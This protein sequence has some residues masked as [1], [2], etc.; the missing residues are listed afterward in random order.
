QTTIRIVNIRANASGLG[1]SGS[2]VPSQVIAFLAASPS[3]SLPLSFPQQTVGYVQPGLSFDLRNCNNTA[4]ASTSFAQCVGENSSGDRNLINGTNGTMQFAVRFTEG[5]QTAFKP[6]LASGQNPSVP[7][8]TY[9]SESGFLKTP[10]IPNSVGGADSATR[11]VARFTNVPTGARVFVTTGPSIGSSTGFHAVLTRSPD[12]V[13][14][15]ATLFCPLTAS[16]GLASAEIPV[17][18]GTAIAVWEV[19]ETNAAALEAAV[20]GVAIAYTPDAPNRLPGLGL[21]SVSGNFGPFYAAGSDAGTMSASSPI[22]RFIDSPQRVDAFRIDSC[23]TNLL[24]PFVTNQS[25]FD[26]GIAIA[27]T[28]RDPFGVTQRPQTGSCTVS[29][30]GASTAGPA[31][32]PQ[33]TSSAV[34]PGSTMTFVL[35]SGGSHGITAVPGFQGY[36]IIR[37]DFRYAHGFAF[38]TDGVIGSARVAEGYLGLVM[39]SGVAT[40]GSTSESLSQ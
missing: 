40:R 13:P 17:V 31:P 14:A 30:Y 6:Q 33:T 24:F 15:T 9:H 38:I 3:Q 18:N 34:E 29:Y 37:C 8:V 12:A 1:V 36:L 20:F 28:S 26:T 7:G 21:A 39:D 27:N 11:L 10:Q 4:S 35:S 32:P 16:S 2:L 19:T 22:P 23:V 5:F 25:G